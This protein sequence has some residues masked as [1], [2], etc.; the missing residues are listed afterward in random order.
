MIS[1]RRLTTPRRRINFIAVGAFANT[2]WVM[3]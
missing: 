2:L 3:M 1:P